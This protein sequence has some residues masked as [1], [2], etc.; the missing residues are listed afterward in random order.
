MT[1]V[2]EELTASIIKVIVEADIDRRFK[3]TYYLNHH[4]DRG[5]KIL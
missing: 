2:S 5:S 3:G 1:D 4:L